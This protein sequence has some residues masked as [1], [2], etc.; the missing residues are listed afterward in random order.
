VRAVQACHERRLREAV[1]IVERDLVAS[2][3]DKIK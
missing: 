3:L 2:F 1:E